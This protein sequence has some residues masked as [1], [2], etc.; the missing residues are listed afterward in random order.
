MNEKLPIE[1][2]EDEHRVIMKV[3]GAM[4]VMAGA[5]E[6]GKH[7][8][9]H[10]LQKTA[11]FM[12][13]YADKCH[14]GKEEGHLFPL[15][16]ARGVPS[17]GCPLGALLHEH[18]TGRTLVDNLD[19]ATQAY[20]VEDSQDTRTKLA[21]VLRQLMKLYPDHIWKEDYLAF[22]L[23]NKV[24]TAKDQQGLRRRFADV[25]TAIGQDVVDKQ[26]AW[27]KSLS[28]TQLRP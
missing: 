21:M 28:Q 5:L 25:D 3:V 7:V 12:K 14:H 27:A 1:L 11:T 24:L 18:Q 23:T 10:T 13:I 17:T 9:V 26:K 6:D 15:L 22:P 19:E 16:Q 2:L 8:A 20:A 4:A